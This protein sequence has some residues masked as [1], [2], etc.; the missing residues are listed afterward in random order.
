METKIN[1]GFF[2]RRITVDY[3][4]R[5]I[6]LRNLLHNFYKKIIFNKSK[7]FL[8][9]SGGFLFNLYKHSNNNNKLFCISDQES[10]QN[11]DFDKKVKVIQYNANTPCEDRFV[12]VKLKNLEGNLMAV[13]D[14]HGGEAVSDYASEKIAQYFDQ[15]YAELCK[16]NT[17]NEKSQDEIIKQTFL[18]TFHKIV[19]NE[20]IISFLIHF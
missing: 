1:F 8:G 16:K 9:I 20:I 11:C 6:F 12:A 2:I 17:K 15:I 7:L 18:D 4:G 14:G 19:R 3:I 13:F 5:K 10:L